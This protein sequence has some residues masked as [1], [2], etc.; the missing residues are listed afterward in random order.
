MLC[1]VNWIAHN[2]NIYL[3]NYFSVLSVLPTQ[4]PYQFVHYQVC[5]DYGS[6]GILQVRRGSEPA[7]NKMETPGVGGQRSCDSS[8]SADDQPSSNKRWSAAIV[9]NRD[10]PTSKNDL[11]VIDEASFFDSSF[12]QA[13]GGRLSPLPPPFERGQGSGA[14][15]DSDR[16]TFSRDANRLSM[17]IGRDDGRWLEAAEKTAGEARQRERGFEPPPP[18]TSAIEA[19]F[20]QAGGGRQLRQVRIENGNNREMGIESGVAGQR[21]EPLGGSSPPQQT[22]NNNPDL[23]KVVILNEI[24]PLGIHVVPSGDPAALG[25]LIQGIEPGG[26]IDRDGRLAVGDRILEING[27]SLTN[28]PFHKAQE[29]FKEA[30]FAKELVLVVDKASQKS[31][32]DNIPEIMTSDLFH[33]EE[34]KENIGIEVDNTG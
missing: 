21:R 16:P 32:S 19:D 20:Q 17:Q 5:G 2:Q 4:S 3:T 29:I 18:C 23:T 10:L 7:L 13:G 12:D 9:M 24:G 31:N 28:C 15:R 34:N 8:S 14:A 30:L 26:R 27:Y 1:L 22:Y 6:G 33:S 11:S 25:L